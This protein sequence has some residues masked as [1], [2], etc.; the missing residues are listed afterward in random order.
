MR[1]S[2]KRCKNGEEII[3]T[4]GED[5][6]ATSPI[7][8]VY[9]YGLD[10]A[11][12]EIPYEVVEIEASY[13]HTLM[14]EPIPVVFTYV[15]DET[16][17]VTTEIVV[18]NP[19]QKGR[20]AVE[21][22]G[23]KV[24]NVEKVETNFGVASTLQYKL[25][26]LGGVEFTIYSDVECTQEVMKVTTD[27][28]GYAYSDYLA[29]GKYYV[30]ETHTLQGYILDDIIYEFDI[31]GDRTGNEF[32][33]DVTKEIVNYLVKGVLNIKK[34]DGEG[35]TLEGV[36]FTL[37]NNQTED[38]YTVTTDK[39]GM[40]TIKN[41]PVGYYNEEKKWNFYVY[42]LEETKGLDGYEMATEEKQIVFELEDGEKEAVVS[43]EIVNNKVIVP[44]TPFVP[45]LGIENHRGVIGLTLLVTAS[46]C[47]AILIAIKIRK[48]HK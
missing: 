27:E 14:E 42:T 5:G 23:E 15:N 26:P 16:S 37:T 4:I 21:K 24:S 34:V 20:I 46:I 11:Y 45:I 41:L 47:I 28:D 35:N 9:V 38:A 17:L 29:V 36:E 13:G 6:T 8:P 22:L 48:I 12:M 2:E 18:E 10:G 3:L 43:I 44:P 39:E 32:V 31:K 30:R 19:V 25:E 7:L 1:K 33:S 40:A